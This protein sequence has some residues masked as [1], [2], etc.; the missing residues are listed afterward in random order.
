MAYVEHLLA[1]SSVVLTR[2][3]LTLRRRSSTREF[4]NLAYLTYKR[5][6]PTIAKPNRK[7]RMSEARGKVALITGITGQDGSYLAE[8]LIEK[9]YTVSPILLFLLSAS[10]SLLFSSSSLRLSLLSSLRLSLSSCFA[11]LLW[12]SFRETL[13]LCAMLSTGLLF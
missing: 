1:S 6:S 4:I 8:L 7:G 2:P 9:G 13:S 3:Y 10:L 5:Q 11:L 12:D